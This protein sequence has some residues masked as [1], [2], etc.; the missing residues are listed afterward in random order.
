[1]PQLQGASPHIFGGMKSKRRG[2]L[3][4][5]KIERRIIVTRIMCSISNCHYWDQGNVCQASQIMVTSDSL[6]DPAP[7]SLDAPQAA[8]VQATPVEAC[9]ETCCK[10]FVERNSPHLYDDQV[11]RK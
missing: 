3:I 5:D 6:A 7:D 10:T 11:T 1:L 9:M 8:T 4:L 2:T